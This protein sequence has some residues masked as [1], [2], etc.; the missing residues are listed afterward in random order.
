[1]LV[2]SATDTFG[3]SELTS[4][5]KKKFLMKAV[6]QLPFKIF[7]EVLFSSIMRKY[8]KNITRTLILQSIFGL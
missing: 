8:G 5:K 6:E 4:T 1:M 3:I 7:R 2:F